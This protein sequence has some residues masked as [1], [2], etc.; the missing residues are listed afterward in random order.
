ML[1]TEIHEAAVE[2]G[3]ALRQAP[4]VAAHHAAQTALDADPA[5]LA[6]MA[7]LRRLQEAFI[8]AQQRDETPSPELNHALRRCQ[9]DVRASAVIMA[10]LRTTNEVKSFLPAAAAEVT[11]SLGADYARSI[12]P[13]SC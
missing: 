13:T 8:G 12:A 6:L 10:H 3:R 5:A 4:A 2:F 1:S 9:A 7:E 11:R